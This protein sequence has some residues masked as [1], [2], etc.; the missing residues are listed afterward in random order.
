MALSVRICLLALCLVLAAAIPAS[1][2]RTPSGTLPSPAL[3]RG[4][5]AHSVKRKL[6]RRA[7]S[8]GQRAVR[9]AAGAIG[10]PYR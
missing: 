1:A 9:I 3:Q 6:H 8:L 7:P 5:G 10:V 2:T 4:P